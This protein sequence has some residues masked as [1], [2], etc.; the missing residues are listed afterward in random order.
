MND[1]AA[2]RTTFC[3]VAPLAREAMRVIQL[4]SMFDPVNDLNSVRLGAQL[5]DA[6]RAAERL[7]ATSVEGR[8]FQLMIAYGALAMIDDCGEGQMEPDQA[9]WMRSAR[10]SLIAVARGLRTIETVTLER[11]YMTSVFEASAN[12]A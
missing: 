2:L 4:R 6:E 12:A 11:Y 1:A 3:P 9:R 5:E 8:F 10:R 7:L